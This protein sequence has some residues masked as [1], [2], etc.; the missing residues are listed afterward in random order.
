MKR[1]LRTSCSILPAI[2]A[3]PALSAAQEI[4]VERVFGP[5]VPT[6]EYKHPACIEELSN[7]DLYLAY[8][9]GKGEY[10]DGTAVFGSRLERGQAAWSPPRVI[11][12]NPFYSLGNPVIWQA[13]DGTAWLFHVTR[14]GET[15]STSRISGKI[16]RDGAKT[17]SDSFNVTF[18]EGT[19]V[20]SRPIALEGGDYLLPIYHETGSDPE[21]T[22]PDTSSLFLRFEAKTKR[23]T[24]T[25]K[26]RS[27]TGNLQPAVVQLSA[28][29]LIAFCR[30]GGGYGPAKD[31]YI[32]RT[33]SRDGGR[34]WS[35]GKDTPLPNPNAAVEL[36][37]LR[38][39]RLLLVY[40]D[41]MSDRTPLT[42]AISTDDGG[43]F[44]HRRNI[45][46]GPGDFAYPSAIQTRDGKIHVVFTSDE[47]KVIRHA[48]FEESAVTKE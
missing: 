46:E 39:G 21:F 2:L 5:E 16:S 35:E 17:W 45:A 23:W 10:A 28:D 27:R 42:A 38:S 29:R 11:A 43:S 36:I 15:W 8:Y 47:R 18:E 33:E 22:A 6:G 19:M 3:L 20:R 32:V 14:Y 13:P 9:G 48:V 31:G 4:R 44:A 25:N 12:S 30:R 1:A 40:N 24:P 7:G 41:S 34:T 26:V 37:K